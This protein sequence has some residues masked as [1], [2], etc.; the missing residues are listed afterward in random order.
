MARVG[1]LPSWALDP[2]LQTVSLTRI[3]IDP[4]NEFFGSFFPFFF[5]GLGPDH[6]RMLPSN[7]GQE[8]RLSES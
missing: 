3:L 6:N 5:F 7:I 4:R 2:D 8:S 1:L